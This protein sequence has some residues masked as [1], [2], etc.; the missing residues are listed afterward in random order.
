METDDNL[1]RSE[2]QFMLTIDKLR[3][4]LEKSTEQKEE[5]TKK[6]EK[7]DAEIKV[8]NEKEAECLTSDQSVPIYCN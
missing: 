3:A 7:R 5:L 4:A 8:K 1:K 6:L 2:Y